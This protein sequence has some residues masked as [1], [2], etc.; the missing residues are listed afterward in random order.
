MDEATF[1]HRTKLLGLQ[2]IRL[3]ATLPRYSFSD[4]LSRQ[5]VRS[6]TSVGANYRAA[7]RSQSRR[8]MI[9]KMSIVEEESDETMYWL[10]L[11]VEGG[12]VKSESVD[13]LMRDADE[14]LAMTHAS[15]RTLRHLNL[16]S[17]I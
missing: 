14:I 1:K 9:S 10:E 12:I 5:L 8:D 15:I 3:A 7:C 4:I 16:K 11:M 6:A 2:A 17:K 13:D